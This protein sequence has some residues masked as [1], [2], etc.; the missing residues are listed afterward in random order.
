MERNKMVGKVKKK[1]NEKML[2]KAYKRYTRIVYK[3]ECL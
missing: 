1:E 2:R 3:R